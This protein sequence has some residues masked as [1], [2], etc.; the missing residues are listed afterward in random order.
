MT[1]FDDRER[2]YESKFVLD[3]DQE[4]KATSRRNR[5]LGLWAGDVLGKSGEDLA[6]YAREVVR[7]DF[8]HPGD[9]D[10]VRK[11]ETDLAGRPEAAQVRA[12]L[13]ELML[14]ARESVAKDVVGHN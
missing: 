9:E 2:A 12:K 11:L 6:E 5:L 13:V 8:E 3:Q 4:F 14:Q 1:T 10:V 7:S